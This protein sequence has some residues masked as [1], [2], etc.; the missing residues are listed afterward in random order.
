[1]IGFRRN[2][3]RPISVNIMSWIYQL[4]GWSAE[5]IYVLNPFG[6]SYIRLECRRAER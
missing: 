6:E 5:I 4:L 2:F 1:M 3:K